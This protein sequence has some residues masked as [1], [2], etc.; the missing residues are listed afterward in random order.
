MLVVLVYFVTL[1]TISGCPN[2]KTFLNRKN[3]K[4]SETENT[5]LTEK[6]KK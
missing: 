2:R 6:A 5:S 4:L 3:Q 1:Q